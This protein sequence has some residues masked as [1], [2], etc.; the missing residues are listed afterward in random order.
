MKNFAAAE[1]S[2]NSEVLDNTS[3]EKTLFLRIHFIQLLS[4]GLF[5]ILTAW[6]NFSF[7]WFVSG[8]GYG[9]YSTFILRVALPG[10]HAGSSGFKAVL[11]ATKPLIILSLVYFAVSEGPIA[12]VSLLTGLFISIIALITVLARARV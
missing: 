3:K 1:E 4:V 9:M 6:I 10:H 2:E 5:P 12:I 11:L 7:V 8:I